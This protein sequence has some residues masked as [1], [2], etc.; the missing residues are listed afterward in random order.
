[1][2][3][4]RLIYLDAFRGFI[5][6]IMIAIH[7][8]VGFVY[9]GD[10]GSLKNASMWVSLLC[11]PLAIIATWAPV[12]VV[13]S[14]TANAYVMFG[15][16]KGRG[17]QAPL[18]RVMSRGLLN[19]A[20]LC[21]LSL[22]NMSSLHHA[23]RFNGK[24]S[25]TLLTGY[26]MQGTWPPFSP[27]L[28]FFNDALGL[29]GVTGIFTTVVLCTLWRRGGIER[30]HRTYWALG[31]IAALLIALSPL[32]H[33]W[34]DPVFYRCLDERH[35]LVAWPLKWTIGPRL[36][37]VPLSAYALFG[38]IFGVALA[39]GA[40][41]SWFRR[42]GYGTGIVLLV[43]FAGMSSVMG[44]HLSE[45]AL[46]T[47]PLKVHFLDM[48]LIAL[49]STLLLEWSEFRGAASRD[50]FAW[51]TG[52]LRRLGRVPLTVFMTETVISILLLKPYLALL[53]AET[54]PRQPQAIV[55]FIAIVLAFWAAA[56]HVWE[57]Y[58]YRYGFEWLLVWL[59]E[60][61]VGHRSQRLRTASDNGGHR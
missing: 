53:G 36:S 54:L 42:V 13:A 18:G 56:V 15:L 31:G 38:A 55:P 26:L 52:F 48:G 21:L 5:V 50:R 61:L 40:D 39:D 60:K 28:L 3:K 25:H 14:G 2:T 9:Y 22:L 43:L 47:L 23:I 46:D 7:P 51:W 20:V 49:T 1:M 59:N 32:L 6:F 16:L 19:G 58:G 12:F 8:L 24:F 41:L 11:A 37:P 29:L 30:V 17:G 10:A 45:L 57:R 4:R 33:A 34:L 35:W 44:F 27:E